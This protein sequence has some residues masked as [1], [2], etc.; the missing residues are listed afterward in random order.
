MN[1]SDFLASLSGAR[2]PADLTLAQAALWHAKKGDWE[3]A[4]QCAQDHAGW[5]GAWVHAY[6]HRWEGDEGNASYWYRRAGRPA[7]RGSLEDEWRELFLAL[8]PATP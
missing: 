4:H 8:V 3:V 7:S 2:P 1:Q 5:E 6:L